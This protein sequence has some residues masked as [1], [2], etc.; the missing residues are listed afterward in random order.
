MLMA[1]RTWKR[2]GDKNFMPVQIAASNLDMR[3]EDKAHRMLG[4]LVLGQ[5]LVAGERI[6]TPLAWFH[7]ERIA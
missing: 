6:D 4:P 3:A 2:T 7:V 1:C 5:R